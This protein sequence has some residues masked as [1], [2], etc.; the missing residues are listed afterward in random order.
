VRDL[1]R[2]AVASIPHRALVVLAGVVAVALG[3]R[4]VVAGLDAQRQRNDVTLVDAIRHPVGKPGA[5]ATLRQRLV[6]NPA[7]ASVLLALALELERQ[8]K[9]AE[10]DA[11]MREAQVLAPA[12]LRTLLPAADYYLRAGKD[13]EALAQMRQAA[14]S[15]PAD[16]PRNLWDAFVAAL[17]TGGHQAFFDGIAR[18]NPPWWNSFFRLA[19]ERGAS[20]TALQAMY[21]IRARAGTAT[22]DERDWMIGRLQRDGQWANAYQLWL[23]ALSPDRQQRIGYIF[24]GGFEYPLASRGFGWLAPVQVGVAVSTEAKDGMTGKRALQV[25]FANKR[26]AEP[27]VYQYLMLVPGRYRFDAR[28][29]TDLE[30]WLGLQWGVYCQD[31]PGR[32]PRQLFHTDRLVGLVD[33]RI[34]HAEFVVPKDCPAQL[35]RLELANPRS[36]ASSPGTVA[37]RLNGRLWFDDMKV[38]VLDSPW[39][40]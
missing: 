9:R 3:W 28:A 31:A 27:P 23:N 22:P 11:A 32:A 15:S 1:Y 7:D 18:D 6:R 10:A 37:V 17:N 29:R 33:W 13:R 34:L 16:V 21:A 38:R 8:G 40:G 4:V 30:S 5:D 24:D 25:A 12:D 36:D 26:F 35:L 14:D 39:G 19:C 2:T 20:A